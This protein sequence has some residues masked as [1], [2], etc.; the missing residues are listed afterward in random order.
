MVTYYLGKL[1]LLSLKFVPIRCLKLCFIICFVAASSF[2]TA[3]NARIAVASNFSTT[4]KQLVEQ[5]NQV[6]DTKIHLSFGSTGKLFAQISQGAPFDGLLAADMERP[7]LLSRSGKGK[8]D[9][10]F[11]YAIGQ[12][13]LLSNEHSISDNGLDV[14]KQNDFSY[15]AIANPKIA[16]YGLAAKQVLEKADLWNSLKSKR[17]RGENVA[18]ALQFVQSGNAQFGFVSLAQALT[19]KTPADH[20]WLIPQDFYQAIEQQGILLT[21]N[22]TAARFWQYLHS[23]AAKQLITD[24]GYRLN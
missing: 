19:L 12:L 2:A 3:Q 23:Q 8:A 11:T 5:F 13:V 6:S 4:A 10:L 15:V 16:P 18:Q 1:H 17:V 9:S 14:L 7:Q 22:P 20:L 24:S 21:D